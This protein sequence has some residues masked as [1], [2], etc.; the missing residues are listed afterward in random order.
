MKLFRRDTI[1]RISLL[2]ALFGVI[3]ILFTDRLLLWL[4]SDPEQLIRWQ[5]VKGWLFVAVSTLVIFFLQIQARHRQQRTRVEQQRS[6]NLYR[7]L[8]DNNP[9]PMW[10]YDL[11]SL[12]FLAVNDAA[13]QKYGYTRGEFRQMTLRD[14]RP[15]EDIE[16]LLADVARTGDILNFAGEWQH[17]RK[18]G[19]L[20]PVEII[21]HSLIF[22]D[23]PA[24]LVIA[25]D[26]SERKQAEAALRESEKRFRTAVEEAPFPIIIHAEDGEILSLN[27]TWTDLTAYTRAEL[28][29]IDDWTERAYG[30]QREMIQADIERLYELEQRIAEGEY[31]ITCKD[32]TQRIWEF[33]STSLGQLPD[34]RRTVISMAVDVTERKQAEQA[35]RESEA[36][37]RHLFHQLRQ[38]MNSVPEGVL[39]LDREGQVLVANPRALDYLVLL[40]GATIGDT[41]THLGNHPL[42]TLLTSPPPGTWHEVEADRRTFNLLAR[43]L[44]SGPVPQGWV[45]VLRDV[46]EEQEVVE[47]MQQQAR[48]AAIGQLAAGLAH[49]FNNIINVILLYTELIEK[50]GAEPEQVQKRLATIKQQSRQ[51]AVLIEQILDFSRRALLERKTLDLHSFL[52]EQYTLLQRTLPENIE[53]TLEFRGEAAPIQADAARLQQVLLNLAFNARDAMP[54]GGRLSFELASLHVEDPKHARLPGMAAGEWV[55]LTVSDTGQGI[56]AELLDRVFEPFFTTKPPGKGT[57]LGLAQVYGIVGQHGGQIQASSKVGVG[58]TFIIYLPAWERNVL[59]PPRRRAA[60]LAQGAGELLLVVEDE[61]ELRQAIAETLTLCHYQVLTASN[62]EGALSLLRQH[63]EAIDLVLTDVIMPRMG[64]MALLRALRGEGW[65]MPVVLMTGHPLDEQA[66]GNTAWLPKPVS[67]AQLTE[68]VRETL[69]EGRSEHR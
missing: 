65:Q 45:I 60:S 14:I 8:F 52:Q 44:E 21:S 61:E 20:F 25:T 18:D 17:R 58:T 27:R 26:I 3:W 36:R 13:V 32:G 34:G 68:T 43:P 64:G 31:E 56:P 33:S 15:P 38:V 5:T 4:V 23:R 28:A 9:L 48:L 10:V 47:Q 51:A 12:A 16:R 2:Y 53:L 35:L 66:P 11:E 1:V 29:T 19:I 46:T 69:D 7:L 40:A 41:L 54:D 49:D 24:R 50:G 42:E 59:A 62:G 39:L 6:E 63:G 67:P 57:G 37:Y 30:K 55:Q 22:D